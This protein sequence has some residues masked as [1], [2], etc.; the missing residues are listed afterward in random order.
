M[1]NELML[2]LCECAFKLFTVNIMSNHK[3]IYLNI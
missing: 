2:C 3:E 1:E